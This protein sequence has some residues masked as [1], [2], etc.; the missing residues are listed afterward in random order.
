MARKKRT[1]ARQA[2]L[3]RHRGVSPARVSK[4]VRDGVLDSARVGKKF[5][6]D[7]ADTILNDRQQ[8]DPSQRAELSTLTEDNNSLTGANLRKARAQALKAE[9]EVAVLQGSLVSVEEVAALGQAVIGNVRAKLLGVPQKAA[10]ECFSSESLAECKEIIEVEIRL[11]LED[12]EALASVVD[13][14]EAD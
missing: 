1:L 13:F 12:L 8:L 6:Q 2:A 10:A 4:L 9:L 7:L 11:A 14:E 5:D 3:A